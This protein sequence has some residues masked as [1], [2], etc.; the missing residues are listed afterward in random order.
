[1]NIKKQLS[2]NK[3]NT[4]RLITKFTYVGHIFGFSFNGVESSIKMM[5][6]YSNY[7]KSPIS[8]VGYLFFSFTKPQI[9]PCT[10]L[11]LLKSPKGHENGV[12]PHTQR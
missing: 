9:T 12:I 1:M 4:L 7:I 10:N 11:S 2:V 6:S 3:R 8:K 5:Q